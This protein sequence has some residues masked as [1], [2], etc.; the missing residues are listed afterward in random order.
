MSISST[1]YIDARHCDAG[2][3]LVDREPLGSHVAGCGEQMAEA[4]GILL[5]HHTE[6][7]LVLHVVADRHFGRPRVEVERRLARLDPPGV[8]P[9]E[10]PDARFDRQALLV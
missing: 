10:R 3:L 5:L 7:G 6:A 4:L 1:L 8:E 9:V 2:E